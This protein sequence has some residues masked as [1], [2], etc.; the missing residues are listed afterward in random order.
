MSRRSDLPTLRL[1]AGLALA[2]L[3]GPPA[4]AADEVTFEWSPHDTLEKVT[5]P[6]G[7]TSYF[8]DGDGQRLS[9]LQPNSGV[10]YVRDAAGKVMAEYDGSGKLLVEYI[11]VGSRRIARVSNTNVRHYYHADAV[12]TPLAI[13][14]E[15]GNEVWQGENL[16]FGRE[17]RS[18]NVRDDKR[19][20]TGKELDDETGL[21]YFNARYYS[22][23]LGR[24]ISV[25]PV[26]GRSE[27]PQTWNR[28]IYGLNNPISFVD[29]DGRDPYRVVRRV[30]E[31]RRQMGLPN[32]QDVHQAH[33]AARMFSDF[34]F[35]A[36]T[37]I[38]LTATPGITLPKSLGTLRK[39]RLLHRL[40]RVG[41]QAPKRFGG[42]NA[43]E[44]MFRD[45][46]L[47]DGGG[48]LQI[49]RT[50]G[51]EDL[52][53][54]ILVDASRTDDTLAIAVE[55]K[56]KPGKPFAGDQ[57]G[58]A[59]EF[60]EEAGFDRVETLSGTPDEIFGRLKDLK[61]LGHKK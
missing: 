39:A 44:K 27:T 37:E 20:F 47:R 59:R 41:N 26:G 24:F 51:G 38:L 56:S 48:R 25:D 31:K 58:K 4:H 42:M 7:V 21:H 33:V 10:E 16:P 6:D 57:L 23:D 30:I 29:P 55:L 36:G 18:S 35:S 40:R 34:G 1:L 11:Y 3:I 53:D 9:K 54:F 15:N 46:I 8:Y 43:S 17:V 32:A 14:D 49:F 2:A 12:G 5:T 22:A 28:Y 61:I 60:L 52:G 45:A 13:T 19:K 50:K